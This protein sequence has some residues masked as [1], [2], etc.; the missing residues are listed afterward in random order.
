MVRDFSR[1]AI[2]A[3]DAYAIAVAIGADQAHFER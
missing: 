1:G 3:V 2:N